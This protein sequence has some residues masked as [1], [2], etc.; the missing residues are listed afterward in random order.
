LRNDFL[1]FKPSVFG[2]LLQYP[3]LSKTGSFIETKHP[4]TINS[5]NVPLGIYPVSW[6]HISHRNLLVMFIAILFMIA[7]I[8]I[9]PRCPPVDEWMDELWDIQ[10]AGCYSA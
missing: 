6:K 1:L 8:W 10:T 9:Q 5:S 2:T 3:E 7:K 4:L